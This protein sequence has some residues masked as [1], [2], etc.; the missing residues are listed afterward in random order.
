MHLPRITG[1]ARGLL[2]SVFALVALGALTFVIPPIT[3]STL[4]KGATM[5]IAILGLNF[6]TGW[7]GQV[8]IGNSG[9]MAVGAFGTAIL[10]QHHSTLP[11]VVTMLLSTL[12]G[13][14]AGMIVG[15]PATRLRGPYLAGM[16]LAFGASITPLIQNLGSVTGGPAGIQ[17]SSI[18]TAPQWLIS[19]RSSTTSPITLNAQ[20][21]AL[22][23][24]LVTIIAMFLMANLEA[25]RLGRAMRLVR[26]NDVAAELVGLSLPRTRVTAFVVSAAY[27][28]L[29]GSLMAYT[30]GSVS[31]QNF[32]VSLSITLL[33]LMV[34]GGMGTLSGAVIG[35]VIYAYS[36]TTITWLTT[37]VG[38]DPISNFGSNL[39]NVIFGSLLII[40]MLTAPQGITGVARQIYIKVRAS[41]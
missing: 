38:V 20:W 41:R 33:S 27:A 32:L 36:D 13:A 31:P 1:T 11:I 22:L 21:L 19:I 7:S 23:A 18:P 24:L 5:L 40:T 28:G 34:L 4:T 6:L 30:Q 14:I 3:N 17:L 2:L 10:L 35:G 39:K 8:S 37:T 9:F 15:L 12:L 16:T 26:D 29:A 25:S